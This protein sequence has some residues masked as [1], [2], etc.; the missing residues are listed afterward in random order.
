MSIRPSGVDMPSMACSRS[1]SQAPPVYSPIIAVFGPMRGLSSPASCSQIFSASGS[2]IE[3]LLQYE[4]RRDRV[5]GLV[6]DTAQA[7]L[8]LH[9]REALVDARHG[10]L[11]AP[12]KAPREVLGLAR[13][14]VRLALH[15]GRPPDHECRWMPFLD[16][17]FYLGKLRHRGQRMRGAQLGLAD[18]H[19]NAL[20]TKIECQYGA[21]GPLRHVPLRP[22]A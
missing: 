7:A 14:G 13:H 11:E 3:I 5:D 4:L 16:Q 1:A 22:A 20:Q 2:F 8:G 18:R 15:R 17:L 9:R 6:P 10:Q 21:G 19:A 12:L